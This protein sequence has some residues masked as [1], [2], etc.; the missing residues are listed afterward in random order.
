VSAS[1]KTER[2]RQESVTTVT[3]TA[4]ATR[5]PSL[6]S[7]RKEP[8]KVARKEIQSPVLSIAPS[9]RR[10][11]YSKWT[12]CKEVNAI[13]CRASKNGD[14]KLIKKAIKRKQGK[15]GK[16]E[17]KH[18]KVAC[19][20]KAESSNS[21]SSDESIHVM[22]PSQRIPCKKR[23]AQRTIQFDSKGKKVD[24]EDSDSDDDRKMPA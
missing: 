6:Q 13:A 18:A 17:K 15:H 12:F 21:D 16:K 22:E 11:P 24:I 20:K 5:K 19:A 8:R 10:A 7:L 14:I 9:A 1:N 4:Q 23:F 2:P 3:M